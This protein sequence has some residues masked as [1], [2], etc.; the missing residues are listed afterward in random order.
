MTWEEFVR[1]AY[2]TFPNDVSFIYQ[3]EITFKGIYGFSKSGSV[4]KGSTIF[5][6][7]RSY[8]QMLAIMKA[9]EDK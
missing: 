5:A 4:M 7:N 8:K 9:L 3:D 1:K 2:R 6:E